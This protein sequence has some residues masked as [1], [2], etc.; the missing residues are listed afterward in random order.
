MRYKISDNIQFTTGQPY[1]NKGNNNVADNRVLII[2]KHSDR[3][4]YINQTIRTFIE[5][6]FTPKTFDEV[7]KEIAF[8]VNADVDKVKKITQPFLRYIKYRQFIIPENYLQKQTPNKALFEANA[9]LDEYKIENVIDI[10]GDIDVYKAL[11]L[12]M[13]KIVVIKLLKKPRKKSVAELQREFSFLKILN[14]AK[15][16]PAA[17]TFKAEENY[18]Y[19]VQEF[20][21]GLSL[22]QFI[23][24]TKKAKTEI[25]FSVVENILKAFK[26][27]HVNNIVHGDIHPS[28][29]VVTPENKIKVIDFGL[30]INIELDKDELVNFGGAYF[31]MPPERIRITTHKKFT[32]KPDFYSDVFQLGIVLFTLLYNKY[33][34]NGI[35][36]EELATE[37]KEKQIEFPAKSQYGFLV[38][39]WLTSIISKCVAKKPMNRFA[40]TME[41]YSAYKKT[42]DNACKVRSTAKI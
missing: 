30:S 7:N 23:S 22:P 15:I 38:P 19:F 11:D 35:T 1:A 42:K 21:D 40:N 6:F 4:F 17:Y 5:K 20:A 32:R 25:V 3:Q 26:E 33:P 2:N 34:F 10:N 29:I 14:K 16:A 9:I 24:R 37:I 39:E 12:R 27:I 36:W 41:L 8:E 28:N 18:A 31:F 13:E